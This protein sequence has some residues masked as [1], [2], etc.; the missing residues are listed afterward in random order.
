MNVEN[1]ERRRS[2]RVKL[3]LLAA[4]FVLPVAAGW[5]IWA[6][7]LAPGNAGNY[8]TLLRPQP[9]A[10]PA[11]AALKGKWVLVQFDGGACSAACERKLYFMRQVRRA[12]GREME[13]VARLWLIT[14]GVQPRPA[15]LQAIEGTVIASRS[16]IDAA[17][18]AFPAEGSVTD[19]IYL[20]DPLGNLMMRF[21]K[22]P[23]PAR[24]I[25]DLQRL[26][27]ASSFG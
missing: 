21:P 16:G 24:V 12:Q 11:D 15:L 25:K 9:V 20:V 10:L 27:R 8:G 5:L 6:L 1:P 17:D 26:L 19:H 7:D 22:D 2:G 18:G 13:R 23:E 14:D 4:F 3:A